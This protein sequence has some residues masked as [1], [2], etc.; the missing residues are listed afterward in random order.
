MSAKNNQF[1]QEVTSRGRNYHAWS[2]HILSNLTSWST[3][4]RNRTLFLF[5]SIASE[6]FEITGCLTQKQLICM[7][8]N[9]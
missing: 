6:Q 7:F 9:S 8:I 4:K 5:E 3:A 1:A 2:S